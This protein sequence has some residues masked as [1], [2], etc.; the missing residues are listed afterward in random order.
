MRILV[1]NAGSSS[2][3]VSLLDDADGTDLRTSTEWGADATR[4][5]DREG[6]FSAALDALDA[7]GGAVDH[8]QAVGHRV[9]HGGA[10]FTAPVAIDEPVL[11]EL[12]R[13]A[14]ALDKIATARAAAVAASPR[15]AHGLDVAAQVSERPRKA[16]R[17]GRMKSAPGRTRTSARGLGNLCSLP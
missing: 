17:P 5:A 4:Q 10:R 16:R 3:K 15:P 11:D 14:D 12:D 1:V 7:Q 9:V 6:G 2:L 8:V 13:L